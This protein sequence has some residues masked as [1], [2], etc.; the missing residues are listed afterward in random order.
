MP[1]I[2]R[3]PR[4]PLV[5]IDRTELAVFVGPLVPDTYAVFLEIT[6]IGFA[7]QEPQQFMDDRLQV[8][9]LGGQQREA[10]LQVKA[11]LRAEYAER[12]GAGAVL[13]AVAV[14]QNMPHQIE[15]LAH[16]IG[17]LSWSSA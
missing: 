4:A 12:A 14:L 2:R 9:L 15:V 1:A 7:L 8:N 11:Q 16:R 17:G 3:R 5:A 10:R 13:L 6:G